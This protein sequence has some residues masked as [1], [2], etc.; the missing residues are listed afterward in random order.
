[1][2]RRLV[3]AADVEFH[4]GGIKCVRTAAQAGAE[5]KACLRVTKTRQG[6]P[7]SII[8]KLRAN[9]G[10]SPFRVTLARIWQSCARPF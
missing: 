3:H 10:W 6:Q 2:D 8:Q 5:T 9:E 4:P 7:D 1:M